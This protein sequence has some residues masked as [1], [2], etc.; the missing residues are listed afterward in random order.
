MYG[1]FVKPH[2]LVDPSGV[3]ALDLGTLSQM[4]RGRMD[5]L[6]KEACIDFAS[7]AV[8]NQENAAWLVSYGV[9]KTNILEGGPCFKPW[10]PQAI[11]GTDLDPRARGSG[12]DRVSLDGRWEYEGSVGKGGYGQI[13]S[14]KKLDEHNNILDRFVLKEAYPKTGW[15]SS[16]TWVG[17]PRR[18]RPKEYFVP[19]YLTYLPD[20]SN[21]IKPRAYA[22]Y[23]NAKMYRLYM[24]YCRHA[25][26][27]HTV[28]MYQSESAKAAGE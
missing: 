1:D 6:A 16:R 8:N 27:W 2:G 13:S 5:D 19:K 7:V 25:D 12:A 28:G 9:L 24:E 21:I 17:N 23:E 4:V 11:T 22:I 20:S 18:R 10:D 26:L 15:D 14:W 3:N